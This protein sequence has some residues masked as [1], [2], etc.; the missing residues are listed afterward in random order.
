MIGDYIFIFVFDMGIYGGGL[1][2]AMG[3]VISC[4]VMLTHFLSTLKFIV[5]DET[6]QDIL[7]V[8]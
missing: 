3:S 1:A 6:N 4:L 5:F 2:T 7:S 8:Q